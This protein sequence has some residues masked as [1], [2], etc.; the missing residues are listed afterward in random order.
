[1]LEYRAV[2]AFEETLSAGDSRKL[3]AKTLWE[4]IITRHFVWPTNRTC[5][6]IR[7]HCIKQKLKTT[8]NWRR[9]GR[10]EIYTDWQRSTTVWRCGRAAKIYMLH[11][12]NLAPKSSSWQLQDT[13]QTLKRLWKHSGQTFN[14]MVQ[15]HIHCQKDHLC[16]EHFLQSTYLQDKLKYWM[17]AESTYLTI[18]QPDVMRIRQLKAFRAPPIGLIGIRTWIVRMQAKTTGRQTTN[19]I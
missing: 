15:L 8:W 4:N 14:M 3:Q 6:V 18:I 9:R 7:H 17:T 13:F 19:P 2:F 16:H 5:Q 1:V 11:R 12:R 10:K